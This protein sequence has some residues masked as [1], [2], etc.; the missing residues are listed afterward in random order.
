MNYYE[1]KK[2]L[3]Q[4]TP[5][6]DGLSCGY[7]PGQKQ[8]NTCGYSFTSV[9]IS[10][11]SRPTIYQSTWVFVE[12]T[13]RSLYTLRTNLSFEGNRVVYRYLK[14]FKMT[15]KN[16]IILRIKVFHRYTHTSEYI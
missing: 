12:L 16:T 13:P 6:F 3:R 9:F 2:V 5:Y 8:F 14:F 1:A 15:L 10:N 7:G 11:P 4:V